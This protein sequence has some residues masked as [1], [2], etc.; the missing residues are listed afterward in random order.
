MSN[1]YH[2]SKTDLI[3]PTQNV[4][5]RIDKLCCNEVIDEST[6]R[7]L[8]SLRDQYDK[9]K[10][11]TRRQLSALEDVE[12]SVTPQALEKHRAWVANFDADKREKMLVCAEYYKDSNYFYML[13]ER[14]LLDPNYIPTENEYNSLCL[15]KYSARVLEATF[16]DP[17]YAV[18]SLVQIRGGARNALWGLAEP[19]Q[20][21]LVIEEGHK[22]V[23]SAAKGAKPYLVLPFGST[24]PIDVEERHIKKVIDKSKK[25]K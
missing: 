3:S 1:W 10:G 7:F 19:N 23:V 8:R 21:C 12:Q 6:K 18:G 4:L 13:A 2:N 22:P 17:L 20:M 11:L 14:I 9:N 25:T 16:S 5:V 15:N 24:V